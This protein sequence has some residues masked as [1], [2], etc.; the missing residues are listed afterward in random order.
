[1]DLALAE[2]LGL[3]GMIGESRD[4]LKEAKADFSSAVYIL[5]TGRQQRPRLVDIWRDLLVSD[6]KTWV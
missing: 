3:L 5:S 4:T 6:L 1:M 2:S